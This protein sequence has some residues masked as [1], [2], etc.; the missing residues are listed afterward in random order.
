MQKAGEDQSDRSWEK[1][2]NV[3]FTCRKERLTHNNSKEGKLDRS[4][5]AWELPNLKKKSLKER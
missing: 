3:E 4:K 2:R 1:W 5:L